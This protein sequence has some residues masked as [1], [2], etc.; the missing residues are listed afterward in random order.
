MK[1]AAFPFLLSSVA[2]LGT[3]SG[4]H[5]A[6]RDAVDRCI[7][8]APAHQIV[9]SG[10]SQHF[11]VKTGDEHY[12]VAFQRSCGSLPTASRV[13]IRAEGREGRLCPGAG[14]VETPRETC[15]VGEVSRIAPEDFSRQQ[16]RRR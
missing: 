10:D 16:R 15:A 6:S 2:L 4:V 11:L 5:A 13:T 7:D 12:K 1:H 9:R 3:A 8:L 14:V